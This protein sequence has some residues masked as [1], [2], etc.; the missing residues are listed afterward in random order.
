[1]T[2]KFRLV[3][4]V[5]ERDEQGN[6]IATREVVTYA[7]LLNRAHLEGLKQIRTT[8]VQAPSEVN[9]MTAISMAEVV[10]Q[11]GVFTDYGDASPTSVDPMIVPH[12]IRMSVT[13]AKVR[14]L[15]DAINV[16]VVALEEL[17]Q[18]YT[19]GNAGSHAN[20]NGAGAHDTASSQSAQTDTDRPMTERQ[21]KYL[22]RLLGERGVPSDEAQDWLL[23]NFGA[24]SLKNITAREASELIDQLLAETAHNE[25]PPY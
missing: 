22:Y 8:L 13:R 15:R 7:G 16:A 18:A 17:S 20:G 11:R 5:E 14:A 2:D 3:R 4:A 23:R 6:V 25:Q 24:G 10:T 19:N 1:M 12:I 21:R 9:G